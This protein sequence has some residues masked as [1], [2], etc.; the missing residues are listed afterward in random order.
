MDKYYTVPE[1][2]E[3]LKISKSQAYRLVQHGEIPCI[4]IGKKSVRI[5]ES[6]LQ[7]WLLENRHHP[8]Q[9]YYRNLTKLNK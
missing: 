5:A 7:E 1:V 6:D 2:A 9:G 8:H 3:I 4:R